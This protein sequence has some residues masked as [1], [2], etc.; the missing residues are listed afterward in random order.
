VFGITGKTK[1]LYLLTSGFIAFI[2]IIFLK[3]EKTEKK[4]FK[5]IVEYVFFDH[6]NR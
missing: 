3:T 4:F 1:F 2:L 5:L 6:K